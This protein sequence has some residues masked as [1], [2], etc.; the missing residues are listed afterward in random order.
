[1][2]KPISATIDEQ[3]I[4]WIEKQCKDSQTYRN[5]SHLIEAAIQL[6][7]KTKK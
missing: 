5:K 1:M 3:L 2:K 7:K 4:E 6:L